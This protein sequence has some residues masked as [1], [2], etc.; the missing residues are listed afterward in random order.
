VTFVL[1]GLILLSPT[2]YAASLCIT[3]D[4]A[5]AYAAAEMVFTGKIAKVERDKTHSATADIYVVTFKVETWWKG[6]PSD[7]VRVLWWSTPFSDCDYLP[8]G[9]VGEDY[10][11]YADPSRSTTTV[12]FPE[13]TIF[14][15][16]SKLPANRKSE[17]FVFEDWSKQP[18]L[19]RTPELNRADAL[20]D[21]A[22]LRVVR[23]CGCLSTSPSDSSQ[24]PS[25]QPNSRQPEGVSACQA[26]LRSRLKPF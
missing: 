26:C 23:A 9:D 10:L 4:A 6:K 8:V 24:P 3:P 1:A 5:P 18:R 2:V 7:E 11:V 13:V 25:V 17:S 12:K 21:I 19:S 22:L 20:G 15:R 14:N 16:T